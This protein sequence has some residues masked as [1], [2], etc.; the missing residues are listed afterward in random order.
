MSIR[1]LVVALLLVAAAGLAWEKRAALQAWA[2]SARLPEAPRLS[3]DAPP[4]QADGSAPQP[5]TKFRA[6]E[7]RKCVNGA[8]VSYSNV[9][10]PPGAKAQAVAAAP[11]TVVPGTPVPKPATAGSGPTAL[12]KALDITRDDTLRDKIMER[13][14]E[15]AR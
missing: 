15:G 10:C 6:G 1:G 2:G 13:Q 4:P 14:I 9:E 12:H 7:L 11:V 3:L 5:A 8:Q